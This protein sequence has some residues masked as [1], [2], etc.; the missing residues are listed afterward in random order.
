MNTLEQAN[1]LGRILVTEYDRLHF[2]PYFTMWG[3]TLFWNDDK[4]TLETNPQRNCFTGGLLDEF[5]DHHNIKAVACCKD[6]KNIKG[7]VNV[8]WT[9]KMCRFNHRVLRK[10]L[11]EMTWRTG[12]DEIVSEKRIL[13]E[14]A[15]LFIKTEGVQHF[16]EFLLTY[17]PTGIQHCYRPLFDRLYEMF[18]EDALD[19]SIV[20]LLRPP[21]SEEVVR[22]N[23][24]ALE[25]EP[26]VSDDVNEILSELT[27]ANQVLE[28]RRP[29]S[30]VSNYLGRMRIH[31][32]RGAGLMDW[33]RY[34]AQR[35]RMQKLDWN[36]K[37]D[38]WI[39][40][41]IYG[42]ESE[43]SWPMIFADRDA[44][45]IHYQTLL[46][47]EKRPAMQEI[48]GR[49][50]EDIRLYEMFD[51]SPFFHKKMTIQIRREQNG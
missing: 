19:R 31:S 29:R 18:E 3:V 35:M 4:Q 23:K 47:E 32:V 2:D 30:K 21:V 48:Y 27:P 42:Q 7:G 28:L 45:R 38:A 46:E 12:L 36:E 37:Y 11:L 43:K 39:K 49:I 40:E 34:I 8:P 50:L 44:A 25:A 41:V 24:E 26:R 22:R 20:G 15:N 5:L 10:Q 6:S 33:E 1:E 17:T 13:N 9:I 51:D 16:W 14:A